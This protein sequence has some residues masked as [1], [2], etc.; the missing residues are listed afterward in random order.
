M[1]VLIKFIDLANFHDIEMFLDND[2]G[3]QSPFQHLKVP[4]VI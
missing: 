2:V 4:S 1:I 3:L